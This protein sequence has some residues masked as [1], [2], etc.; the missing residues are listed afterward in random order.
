[1][2]QTATNS[3]GS[4]SKR[5]KALGLCIMLT[6][7]SI[8]MLNAQ[9]SYRN[10]STTPIRNNSGSTFICPS[11]NNLSMVD[12]GFDKA[13]VEWD[14]TLNFETILF[15]VTEMGSHGTSIIPIHGTPNPGRYFI[16]GLTALTT[17]EIEI[18]TVCANGIQSPWTAP[19]TVTTLQPRLGIGNNESQPQTTGKLHV[20]PNPASSNAIVSLPASGSGQQNITI[21][22]ASGN[23]MLKTVV[24][25][26]ADKRTL[27][28]DVSNYP[29]GVYFVKVSNNTGVS[30][31]RLIVQ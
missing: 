31:E 26:S 29:T 20:S 7:G 22:S 27:N 16:M 24:F 4:F 21:T 28:V 17:Y 9:T 11:I 14:N 1:M 25:A 18:S 15:R 23:E 6:A 12:M 19:I 5:V 10:P 8:S 2:K 3:M 13:L 30:V